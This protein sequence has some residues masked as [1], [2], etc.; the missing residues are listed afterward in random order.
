[1]NTHSSVCR[2]HLP[3][4][5][6]MGLVNHFHYAAY[7][8]VN[9]EAF[10]DG[11]TK[12]GHKNNHYNVVNMGVISVRDHS[13]G[14]RTGITWKICDE[15]RLNGM[16]NTALHVCVYFRLDHMTKQPLGT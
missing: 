10:R 13:T 11:I 5:V 1:M 7:A 8:T 4:A 2:N 16:N 12:C 3:T 14:S 15:F 6:L 9:N